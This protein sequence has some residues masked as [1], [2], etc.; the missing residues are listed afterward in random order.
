MTNGTVS[1]PP[2]SERR[3]VVIVLVIFLFPAGLFLLWRS[4]AFSPAGKWAVFLCFV[5]ALIAIGALAPKPPA[6]RVPTPEVSGASTVTAAT[7]PKATNTKGGLTEQDYTDAASAP[8]D[9]MNVI[10]P[11]V[12]PDKKLY[13]WCGILE[14]ADVSKELRQLILVLGD[15]RRRFASFDQNEARIVKAFRGGE[16]RIGASICVAGRYVANLPYTTVGGTQETMPALAG[17][18]IFV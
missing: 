6:A 15:R 8:D 7:Q 11:L 4:R 14:H 17:I 13:K 16:L 9:L 18:L 2:W 1:Q 10:R 12:E 5:L 3:S